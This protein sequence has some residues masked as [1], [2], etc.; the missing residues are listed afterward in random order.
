MRSAVAIIALLSTPSL[1]VL[2]PVVARRAPPPSLGLG[3]LLFGD[4]R[5][6]LRASV[7]RKLAVPG[8][9][10]LP[11]EAVDGAVDSLLGLVSTVAPG[12]SADGALLTSIQQQR[13][14]L[15]REWSA[16]FSRTVQDVPILGDAAS[17]A[18]V[19]DM[20]FDGVFDLL[21]RT[22]QF[23][24]LRPP[25]ERLRLAEERVALVKA[26]LGVLRLLWIRLV[27]RRRALALLLATAYAAALY[28]GAAPPPSR[29]ALAAAATSARAACAAAW[30]A[31]PGVWAAVPGACAAAWAAVADGA[32]W[33]LAQFIAL[34]LWM[35]RRVVALA[36]DALDAAAGLL[37]S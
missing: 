9:S 22:E 33:A 16:E 18:K 26:E 11:P 2:R 29:K 23:E 1:A 3:R 27:Q 13:G 25:A 6:A 14:R 36:R 15:R 32:R 17:R 35:P 24:G 21:L 20:L 12:F 10:S 5:A 8:L 34:E 37:R 7:K 31:L 28:V 19:G 4:S 30:A